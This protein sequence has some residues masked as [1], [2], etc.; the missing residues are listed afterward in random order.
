M[1]GLP[2]A[3]AVA[4]LVSFGTATDFDYKIGLCLGVLWADA[5]SVAT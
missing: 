2:F 3:A 4:K 1:K 5:Y